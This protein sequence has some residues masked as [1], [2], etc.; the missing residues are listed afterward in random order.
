MNEYFSYY[1][2]K[3][4][5][6]F[7]KGQQQVPKKVDAKVECNIPVKYFAHD[8]LPKYS[9]NLL[10]LAGISGALAVALAAY[11]SHQFKKQG[12]SV[13]LRDLFNTAQYYHMV[14][15]IALLSLPL[16][17]KPFLVSF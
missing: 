6:I 4:A 5:K 10:R 14:H 7:T 8:Q 13:E 9:K 16:V 3:I 12:K 15:S 2:S 1:G 11:G 17:K